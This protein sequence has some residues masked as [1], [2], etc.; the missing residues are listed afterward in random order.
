VWRALPLEETAAKAPAI[1]EV[2]ETV[3]G[4]VTKAPATT[5]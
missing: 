2:K 4:M 3:M 5:R 1:G